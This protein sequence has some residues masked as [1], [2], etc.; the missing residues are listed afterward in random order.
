MTTTN[1]KIVAEALS[2]ASKLSFAAGFAYLSEHANARWRTNAG[3]QAGK[4]WFIDKCNE[5]NIQITP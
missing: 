2:L 1:Q 4:Q 5:H 3:G